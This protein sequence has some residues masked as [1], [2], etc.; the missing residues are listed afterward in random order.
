[1]LTAAANMLTSTNSTAP[2]FQ[3]ISLS[4]EHESVTRLLG[5]ILCV[6]FHKKKQKTKTKLNLSA[7]GLSNLHNSHICPTITAL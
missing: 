6:I 7:S 1:M 4:I 2:N 3:S 5:L